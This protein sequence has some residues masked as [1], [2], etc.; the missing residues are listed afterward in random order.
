MCVVPL[1]PVSLSSFSSLPPPSSSP[2]DSDALVL[3]GRETKTPILSPNAL[4]LAD[5][6]RPAG[7]TEGLALT[8]SQAKELSCNSNSLSSVLSASLP[9]SFV[10]SPSTLISSCVVPAL[11]VRA[12]VRTC[13]LDFLPVLLEPCLLVCFTDCS[14]VCVWACECV[15]LQ[16]FS[17]LR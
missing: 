15:F 5:I 12:R 4:S 16:S 6:V 3:R 7:R 1:A 8:A 10:S 9:A 13:A 2:L 14:D 11:W 17:I